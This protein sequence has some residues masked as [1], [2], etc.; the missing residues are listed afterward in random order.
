MK[1]IITLLLSVVT[2][3]VACFAFGGCKNKESKIKV[4]P[5][6]LSSE[7][8]AFAIKKGDTELKNSIN[9]FFKEKKSEIE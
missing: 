8:Y 6:S 4:V 5:V 1:K 7:E 2:V 3:L 9:D